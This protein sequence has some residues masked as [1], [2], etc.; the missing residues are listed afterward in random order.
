MKEKADAL[1]GLPGYR[2]DVDI[3]KTGE[4]GGCRMKRKADAHQRDQV[5]ND[6]SAGQKKA[7]SV[8]LK[9][10]IVA[11]IDAAGSGHIGGSMSSLDLLLAL[12]GTAHISPGCM[13]DAGRDRI[14]VSMGHISPA[15]YCVLA[16]YGF[17]SKEELF[18]KY[19][20]LPGVFEGHPSNLAPGV[21]WCNGCLGQ[22]LS[23]GCGAAIAQRLQ[24]QKE[25][26]VYVLMGDGE[27]S[28]GQIQEAIELAAKE[29]L[30][31]LVAIVDQNGQQASGSTKEVLP[32]PI[33]ERYRGAGWKVIEINGHDYDQIR[34]A[35][36]E[37]KA[38][39][40]PTC[41]LADTV[42]GKDIPGIEHDWHYHGAR[43]DAGQVK[44]ALAH[45]DELLAAL[46]EVKL[47]LRPWSGTRKHSP[48]GMVS[49][50]CGEAVH[51]YGQEEKTDGRRVCAQALADFARCNPAGSMCVLDCDLA[52]GL[53]IDCLNA[54]RPGTMLE[55]GIQE[56]NALS[57]AGGI[58]AGGVRTFYMGFGMFALAE[59]F[60]QLRV[61]DQNH[62]PLKIIA[63]HCGV[64]VGQDGKSH[65]MIDYIALSNAL[66]GSELMIPADPN[67]A[68]RAL[69]YLAGT[70]RPGILALPR[71]VFPVLTDEQGE[72]LFGEA[73]SYE[74]GRADWIRRGCDAV[75]ITYGIMVQKALEARQMLEAEGL[76]CGILN[77]TAPK[78]LD[79]EKIREAAETGVIVVIEDHNRRSGL[80]SLVGTFLAEQGISCVYRSLGVE[81]YGISA[82]PEAQFTYQNLTA[83]HLADVVREGIRACREK[84]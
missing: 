39:D 59:P 65:Q 75:I 71:S 35:F 52:G 8:S 78:C 2:W 57:T 45:L 11:L 6:L 82:G 66:L 12:Y 56:H 22:G 79:E 63:S 61:I 53:G 47:P 36:T 51:V 50:T 73:Y 16:E 34:D 76:T 48:A 60:N 58:A 77:L 46:P 7:V 1:A 13:E 19:R 81:K 27:Q 72:I 10:E 68:D 28:K 29:H 69:R 55:C 70:D 43:L 42:M 5:W 33:R 38:S 40:V 17:I 41:I 62:I 32:V 54:I 74:Y 4:E 20:R 18:E 14:I 3:E 26:R 21:E 49:F 44:A 80:G 25:S 30:S 84:G 67:Q 64:D 31:N 15:Y 24:G 9:K 37:A 83:G 23:Q